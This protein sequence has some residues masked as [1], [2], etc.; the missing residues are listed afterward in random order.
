MHLEE[1]FMS[2]LNQFAI[3]R[4]LGSKMRPV[5]PARFGGFGALEVVAESLRSSSL[6][7]DAGHTD[8]FTYDHDRVICQAF[9]QVRDGASPD[10]IL[11][12]PALQQ[13][14]AKRCRELGLD[15]PASILNRRLIN[16]RK[17]PGRYAK[18]GIKL[19]PTTKSD[20]H[21]SVVPQYAPVIEFALVRLRYR[22]G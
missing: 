7:A 18:H 4:A 9:E 5:K 3:G 15:A 6:S 14:F 12:N 2:N 22:Y 16:I 10:A 21:P 11:W 1:P 19:S 13:K 20:L 17:N 8:R